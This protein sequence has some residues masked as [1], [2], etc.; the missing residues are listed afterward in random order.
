MSRPDHCGPRTAP[1]GVVLC[2]AVAAGLAVRLYLAA[3]MPIISRDG[4]TFISYA[5][6]W[7]SH[8]LTE[9][10]RQRQHPLYPASIAAVESLL[11]RTGIRTADESLRWILAGQL[12]AVI[13]SLA[14][15]IVV[16]SLASTLF[17]RQV[18]AVAAACAALLPEPARYGV[19]VLSDSLHLLLY[20]AGLTVGAT[21]LL[22]R[23]ASRLALGGLLSGLAFLTR[24][25]GGEVVLV[26]GAGTILLSTAPWRHRF[27]LVAAC[28]IGF[29]LTAGP[30][31]IATGRIVQKKSIR[32][33]FSYEREVAR[34]WLPIAAAQ[35]APV[36]H[37]HNAT[38][39]RRLSPE[40]TQGTWGG[41]RFAAAGVAPT[42]NPGL[43]GRTADLARATG[44][45]LLAWV[46]S[47][48]VMYLLP[49]LAW[50]V[51]RSRPR[52]GPVDVPPEAPPAR[53]EAD[54]G[55]GPSAAWPLV[56]GAFVLHMIVCVLLIPSYGYWELFSVRHVLVPAIL[57]LPLSAAG[58]FQCAARL[59]PRTGPAAA[60]SILAA[61][62][63]AP[64][65]P[66][67]LRTPNRED[68]YLRVAG[69]WIA[70]HIPAP[71]RVM[72]ERWRVALYARAELCERWEGRQL[73]RW[74]GTADAGELLGWIR[75]QRPDVLVL[76]EMR[77]RR[78]NEF[79]F[80]ELERVAVGPGLLRLI[81]TVD[82]PDPRRPKRALIY[83]VRLDAALPAH[84]EIPSGRPPATNSTPTS[85]P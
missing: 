10:R 42:G 49:A 12:A 18:G 79:F 51:L 75:S 29:L 30:Y 34:R 71:R 73:L 21:G 39:P 33:F 19:D 41:P 1:Y 15:I 56:A 50:F 23:S 63:I 35:R 8:P 25:E 64:T 43:A 77:L 70:A 27:V 14:L 7:Q 37:F 5:R 3:A 66:W 26:L 9:M 69:E 84:P 81:H 55:A 59:S 68:A 16:G 85:T 4:A 31:M 74:P 58:L 57:T 72:T 6:G 65:L 46:R 20:T 53:A 32:R 67:L 52:S 62:V 76:D 38:G 47:L 80:E 60:W 36:R 82:Q 83:E 61:V 22:R 48:R 78:Q 24:P 17:N 45:V 11:R 54:G 28:G 44:K 2:A 13:P 40:P